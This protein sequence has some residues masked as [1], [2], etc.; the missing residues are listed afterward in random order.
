MLEEQL[1][2]NDLDLT[3]TD[4]GLPLLE[5]GLYK[6]R[7]KNVQAVENKKKN[8]QNLKIELTLEQTVKSTKGQEISAGFPLFDTVSLVKTEK[9]DPARR[10]AEFQEA[11]MGAKGKLAPLDRY[12]GNEV[13]VKVSIEGSQDDEFGEQNRIK[14]YVKKA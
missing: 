5:P 10:L 1:N 3:N 4:T 14:R 8:G 13:H 7:V 2:L 12:I 6:C 11:T 9:Y